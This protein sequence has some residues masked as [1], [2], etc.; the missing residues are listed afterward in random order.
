[1]NF[2]STAIVKSLYI[3]WPFCPYRCHFCPFVALAGQDEF[4]GVYHKALCKEI[5][6]FGESEITKTPISTVFL[7]GGTPSTMPNEMLLDMSGILNNVFTFE[8]DAEITIEVNPGTVKPGQLEVWQSAGINRL[9]IGV[10]SLNN[11]VLKKLNRHQNAADVFALLDS[12]K[13]IFDNLSIDLIVGLPGVSSDD[14]KETLK[15]VVTLPIKHI[16]IYFLTVHEDTPLYFGVKQKKILLPQDNQI[17]DLYYWSI[18]YLGQNGFLQYEIS[19]FAKPGYESRH[20]SAYW[21]RLPYKAFGL[22]AC[23]FDGN[24]RF[25]N[26]KNL[27]KYMDGIN[28]LNGAISFSEKLTQEQVWVEKLMLGLR[29]ISGMKLA[30]MLDGLD[31]EKREQFLGKLDFLQKENLLLVQDCV[32][33]LTKPGLSLENE[34]VLRLI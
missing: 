14:W 25:Q 1:M 4:M 21:N 31:F 17:V 18:D 34:I 33:K 28:N 15:T 30:D 9:S 24:S 29:K 22:G 8:D 2:D 27:T 13:N 16:S 26:E 3:H 11:Q 23:S 5:L 7:G 10:Q 19:N 20:N 6:D 12:A 32:V